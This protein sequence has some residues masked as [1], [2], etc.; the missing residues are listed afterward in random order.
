[1]IRKDDLLAIARLKGIP[2]ALA[3]T[4]YLQD[5]VLMNICN[6]FGNRLIFKGGTCL[7]KIYQLNR[8]SEDLDFTAARNFRDGWLLK[9]LPYLLGLLDINSRVRSEG[10]EN[11]TNVYLD[12]RG[13][14]YEG[15]KESAKTIVINISLRER[16]QLPIVRYPYLPKYNEIR[17]FD[18]YAMSE[19]EILAEKVRAVYTR[20]KARD[21]YDLWYL[22]TRKSVSLDIPLANRKLSKYRLRFSKGA[23]LKR[24]DRMEGSWKRDLSALVSGDLPGFELVR[25]GIESKLD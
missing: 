23:F 5:M 11:G 24:I 13:P 25:D 16:V 18:L 22:L 8:F 3:E 19:K 10:F 4:D 1:M 9:R 7:Y 20:D 12:I 15:T 6:E 21:V 14:L 17:P 2:V